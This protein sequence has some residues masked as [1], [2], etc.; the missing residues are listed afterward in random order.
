M[1]FTFELRDTLKS[2][3]MFLSVKNVLKLNMEYSVKIDIEILEIICHGSCYLDNVRF[4]H[5]TLLFS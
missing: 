4:R 2:L 5:F 3:S 1:Y